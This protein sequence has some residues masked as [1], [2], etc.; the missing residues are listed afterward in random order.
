MK[1][2]ITRT[3]FQERVEELTI[4]QVRIVHPLASL[5]L[6]HARQH[7]LRLARGVSPPL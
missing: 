7:R 5:C 2:N 1:I 6:L 3:T 4:P